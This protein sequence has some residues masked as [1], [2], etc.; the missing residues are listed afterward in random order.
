MFSSYDATRR[1][2]SALVSRLPSRR[3]AIDPLGV[4]DRATAP[5]REQCSTHEAKDGIE[6]TVRRGLH[7]TVSI[8]KH[9]GR[10]TRRSGSFRVPV[11][12]L[13]VG[14]LAQRAG[15]LTGPAMML[16]ASLGAMSG[17]F[18]NRTAKVVAGVEADA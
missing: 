7:A 17:H 8:L 5:A 13:R 18:H 16:V 6:E 4:H 1:R 2:G 14:D 10:S 12:G 11:G 9:N 15:W 3:V